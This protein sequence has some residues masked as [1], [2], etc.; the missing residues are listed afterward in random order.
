MPR[1]AVA[2]EM[3]RRLATLIAA[4]AASLV[5]AGA[6][7]APGAGA[8]SQPGLL[9]DLVTLRLSQKDLVLEP[10]GGKLLLRLSNEIGNRGRG[11]LEIYP[12]ESSNNCDGDD[13]PA[14]DRDVY[15]RIF[16]DSNADN[17]FDRGQD[18]ES[19]HLLFGCERYHPA[20]DHWHVLDFSRYKLVRERSGRTVVRSTKIG[21][22]IIDTDHRFAS[23]PGSPPEKYYPAGS[24]DCDQD[25]IDGLSVGWADT[26][27]YYLP[28]QQLDVTGLR[29][30]RYCLVSTADPH[31]LL[32]ESDNSN[33][34]HRARIALHPAKHTVERLHGHCR[35]HW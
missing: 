8:G 35:R 7:M 1:V 6:T 11:P 19:H 30:G 33:N 10:S 34:A 14:N 23:L 4:A 2:A 26:Y 13:N 3:S 31:N 16:L 5:V 20:H 12:S 28:G 25:S 29:H 15:Q 21:F 32:R 18:L 27:A 17:V 22:C 24:E 9:P